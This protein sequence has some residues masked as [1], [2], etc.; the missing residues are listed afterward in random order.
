[1]DKVLV[2]ERSL[3]CFVAGCLSVIPLLGVIPAIVAIVLGHLVR[4]EAKGHWNPARL[5]LLCGTVLAW[6]GLG[7]TLFAV[8]LRF[9]GLFR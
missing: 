4:E 7:V 8:A 1:M 9:S 5:H 3:R 6:V 2:I